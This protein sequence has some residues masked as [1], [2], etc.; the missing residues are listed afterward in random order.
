[1][2][3]AAAI[4]TFEKLFS[5]GEQQVYQLGAVAD[6]LFRFEKEINA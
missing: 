2:D 5:D 6:E 3:A 4:E 1:V